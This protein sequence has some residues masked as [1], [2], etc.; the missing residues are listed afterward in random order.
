MRTDG[1]EIQS[2]GR[3]IEAGQPKVVPSRKGW[4]HGGNI[5]KIYVDDRGRRSLRGSGFYRG[6]RERPLRVSRLRPRSIVAGSWAFCPQPISRTRYFKTDVFSSDI[7]AMR[8]LASVTDPSHRG[9]GHI[10]GSR[11][12]GRLAKPPVPRAAL[13]FQNS[14]FPTRPRGDADLRVGHAPIAP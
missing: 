13:Y 3:I 7:S 12:P 10:P 9:C 6:V 1:H 2:F 11:L 5:A 14:S 4:V 8:T